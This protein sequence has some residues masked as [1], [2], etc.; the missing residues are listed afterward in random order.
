MR[1]VMAVF[2][3]ILLLPGV[4][5]MYFMVGTNETD[6][7][8]IGLWF[9]CFFISAGGVLLLLYAAIGRR[10]RNDRPNSP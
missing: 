8:L 2:G 9:I 1:A 10:G 3:I 4:C 6:T 5:A 7:G